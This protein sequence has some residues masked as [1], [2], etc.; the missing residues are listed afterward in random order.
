M[1]L[2]RVLLRARVG[3]VE[4]RRCKAAGW[5][6]GGQGGRLLAVG[7]HDRRIVSGARGLE[8]LDAHLAAGGL[9]VALA[10]LGEARSYRL[11]G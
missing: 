1:P 5:R 3:E 11:E 4:T 10:E 2:R 7:G 8:G 9:P 6:R